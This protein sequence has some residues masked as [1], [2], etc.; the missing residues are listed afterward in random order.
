MVLTI[1]LGRVREADERE[2]RMRTSET[3]AEAGRV[4]RTM[5]GFQE[6]RRIKMERDE[7][8]KHTPSFSSPP[9]G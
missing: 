6:D 8:G 9:P 4:Q 5:L 7:R 1:V 2:K 3:E